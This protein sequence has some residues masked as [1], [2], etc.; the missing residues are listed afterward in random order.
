MSKEM[1]YS[2]SR[3]FRIMEMVESKTSVKMVKYNVRG[4]G[5]LEKMVREN[6]RHVHV[7]VHVFK[8]GAIENA[9][10]DLRRQ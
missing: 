3:I 4:N 1:V 7:T 5:T 10:V 8:C 6:V 2:V 9:Q